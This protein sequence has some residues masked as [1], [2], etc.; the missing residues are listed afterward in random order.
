MQ[1][2]EYYH[3][4]ALYK[5]FKIVFFLQRVSMRSLIYTLFVRCVRKK[6][7]S[8][9]GICLKYIVNEKTSEIRLYQ[10]FLFSRFY[11]ETT[12]WNFS[13]LNYYILIAVYSIHQCIAI[14]MHLEYYSFY[15]CLN[16][17]NSSNVL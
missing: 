2:N 17:C 6:L 10:F 9:I 16:S 5:T 11:I 12:N 7:N 8:T 3:A 1:R 4:Y 13:F 15:H 14:A